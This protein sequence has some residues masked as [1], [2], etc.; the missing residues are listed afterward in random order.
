[1][2]S[3]IIT[4]KEQPG[5]EEPLTGGRISGKPGCSFEVIQLDSELFVFA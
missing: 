5:K 2:N 4:S 1:M 3:I